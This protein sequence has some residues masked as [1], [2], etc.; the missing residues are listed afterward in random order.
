MNLFGDFCV[1]KIKR[2]AQKPPTG[3]LNAIS[4]YLLALLLCTGT[5]YLAATPQNCAPAQKD[6]FILSPSSTSANLSADAIALPVRTFLMEAV[7]IEET[8][9]ERSS[10]RRYLDQT[11]GMVVVQILSRPLPNLQLASRQLFH[12][13]FFS[14][15]LPFRLGVLRL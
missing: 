15:P 6:S 10:L 5:C 14:Q 7:E 9:E 11:T 13:G 4:K 2:L 8:E 12:P 3:E 1:C